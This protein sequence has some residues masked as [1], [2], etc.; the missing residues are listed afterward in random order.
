[1]RLTTWNVN[2]IRNPF[3]YQPWNSARTFPAMFD[4][5]GSDIIVMQELKIQRKDLRDDMVLLDGWDCYFSLPKHKKGYSGVGMYTRNATCSP[6]RAEEGLLGVLPSPSGVPYCELPEEESIGGYPS[7]FQIAELGVDPAELDAEGRCLVLEFPAFV[8]LGVYSPA[9]SNGMRDDF[10]YGF[11]CTLDCRIRN[12]MRAGKRVVLVGDLNVSRDELDGASALEDIRK[13]AI[14]HEEYISTPNRRIFN[15]LLIG[16]E[17]IGPRD[18]GREEGVL[19]D[20][21]RGLH[22]DRKGM[23]THWEQKINARPGNFGSRIDF[24]LVCVSMQ[25]WVKDANTQE[26]LLGSDHCP[27]YAD[28]HDTVRS[29]GN[30]VSL[31]DE[32][33]PPGVFQKGVRIKEWKVLDVPPFSGKRLPEFD[34]RRSI[35]SMFAAPSLRQSSSIALEPPIKPLSPVKQAETVGPVIASH[36]FP[37][38]SSTAPDS[39]GTTASPALKR[40]ES[41]SAKPKPSKRQKS[42]TPTL[43]AKGQRSMKGFLSKGKARATELP[44]RTAGEEQ[45]TNQRFSTPE[46]PSTPTAS[47]PSLPDTATTA[48]QHPHPTTAPPS[49]PASPTSSTLSAFT[50]ASPSSFTA[51]AASISAT[52]RTWSTLFSRPIAPLCEG[53]S[54]PCKTMQTKKKGS[55]QGRSFWMCARPLGPSGGKEK[56]TQWRCGT[57]VWGSEWQGRRGEERVEEAG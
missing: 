6:I 3:S 51:H 23:Y 18:E 50:D 55:N 24:V 57:F 19:W 11:I 49:A 53:H 39:I 8:L 37:R 43:A 2:G 28:F 42:D 34:K 47:V 9:N 17:V 38:P 25:S 48:D 10:R 40:K 4:I 16:G 7:E 26:G 35:K 15:Q 31:S 44:T 54:E 30:E 36:E 13:A 45:Q 14:T 5:L 41:V 52:Q 21:T 56:G 1:M 32:M 12:L 20:T 33:S 22:P 29:H 46:P 27:V